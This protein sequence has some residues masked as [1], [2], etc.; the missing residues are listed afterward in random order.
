VRRRQL[1]GK[2]LAKAMIVM[3]GVGEDDPDCDQCLCRRRP[4]WRR[5][6]WLQTDRDQVGLQGETARQLQSEI[7][8][9]IVIV[10]IVW[11]VRRHC[12]IVDSAIVIS[13]TAW[14]R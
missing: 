5:G 4:G 14:F 10:I 9:K 11:E 6:L 2:T 7:V 3:R 12:Q 8:E 13:S 1:Q